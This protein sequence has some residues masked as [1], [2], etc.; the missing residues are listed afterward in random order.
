MSWGLK[1]MIGTGLLRNS[2]FSLRQLLSCRCFFCRLRHAIRKSLELPNLVEFPAWLSAQFFLCLGK[3][4]FA[5]HV[6]IH[7][8]FLR[9]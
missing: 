4:L 9:Q 8:Q 5:E 7:F 3:N 1:I 2:T 6:C